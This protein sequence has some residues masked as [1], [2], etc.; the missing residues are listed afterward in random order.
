MATV[1]ATATIVVIIPVV[2]RH[3]DRVA[4]ALALGVERPGE[5]AE[6]NVDYFL[7]GPQL[8]VE[9]RNESVGIFVWK[10]C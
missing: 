3:R 4:D 10:N 5:L 1:F 2:P 6:R 8:P 9:P 7:R